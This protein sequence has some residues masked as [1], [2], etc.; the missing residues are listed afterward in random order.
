MAGQTHGVR[1]GTQAGKTPMGQGGPTTP[2]PVAAKRSTQTVGKTNIVMMAPGDTQAQ[3]V[4]LTRGGRPSTTMKLG[5][6]RRL[7]QM[8]LQHGVM[9]EPLPGLM[10][11]ATRA[12]IPTMM[13]RAAVL[14]NLPMAPNRAGVKTAQANGSMRMET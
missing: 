10:N 12:L 7:I 6:T 5:A 4:K 11:S 9:T 14:R 1:M 8:D 2:K 3:T 13:I